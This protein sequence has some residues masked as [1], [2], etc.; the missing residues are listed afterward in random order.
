M[1]G[2]DPLRITRIARKTY[3]IQ[4]YSV[5]DPAKHRSSKQHQQGDEILC[6]DLFLPFVQKEE[7]IA[8]GTHGTIVVSPVAAKASFVDVAFYTMDREKSPDEV[9]QLQI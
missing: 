7:E 4:T 9:K 6:K 2:L 8:P 5:F 1:F 3:G